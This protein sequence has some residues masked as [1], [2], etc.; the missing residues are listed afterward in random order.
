MLDFNQMD[1]T[2]FQGWILEDS[3]LTTTGKNF[4]KTFI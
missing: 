4:L 1:I 2:F 3:S